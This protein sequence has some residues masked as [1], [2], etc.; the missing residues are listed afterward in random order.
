MYS[1]HTVKGTMI[2][3]TLIFGGV[4]IWSILKHSR[5]SDFVIA[6]SDKTNSTMD[7][8]GVLTNSQPAKRKQEYQI[9]Q[10]EI[11]V[12]NTVSNSKSGMPYNDS[13]KLQE[14]IKISLR[15][16]KTG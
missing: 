9:F 14:Y 1:S 2:A 11:G 7:N 3:A 16:S 5:K 10:E 12:E 6:L 13:E 8:N 15:Y 4:V